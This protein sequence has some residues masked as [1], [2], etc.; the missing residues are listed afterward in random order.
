[1]SHALL[2]AAHG[3]GAGLLGIALVGLW[4]ADERGRRAS[5]AGALALAMR[6]AAV[7]EQRLLA[8]GVLMLGASGAWLVA[9]YYGG[10]HFVRIP[11]LAGMIA[12]FVF[13]ATWANTVGRARDARLKRLLARAR[14]SDRITPAIE[15]VRA[16]PLATFGHYVELPVFA[17]VV[18]LGVWRP[19]DWNL[20][21]AGS[22]AAVAIAAAATAYAGRA[23][24]P[25]SSFSSAS[26][27]ADGGT[28]SV[29]PST[30]RQRR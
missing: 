17:L 12:L 16:A 6:H 4:L 27:D 10:W 23:A 3:L 28:W 1:M 19:M 7:I 30:S 21:A 29:A 18:A 15:R 22:V 26:V 14:E 25:A 24:L 13:Q 20:F 9:R 8:P 2:S 5:A 11:W